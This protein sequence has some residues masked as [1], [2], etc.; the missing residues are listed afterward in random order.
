MSAIKSRFVINAASNFA[1]KAL[2]A[3]ITLLMVPIY[4]KYLGLESYGL[5]GFFATLQAAFGVLD[6]GMTATLNRGLAR[7]S[8]RHE[9]NQE[10][11]D[12][13]KTLRIIYYV[14]SLSIGFLIVVFSPL[15]SKYWIKSTIDTST[16]QHAIMMMGIAISLQWPL[17]FFNSGILGLQHQAKANMIS[18]T[19][20]LVRAMGAFITLS[21]LPNVL[22]F[23][24]WQAFASMLGVYVSSKIL[25][26]L[27]PKGEVGRFNFKLIT[28]IKGYAIGMSLTGIMS[29]GLTQIDKLVVSAVVPLEEFAYYSLAVTFSSIIQYL[30]TPLSIALLPKL[31]Q[32]LEN[33]E[34]SKFLE[35]YH[36]SCQILVLLVIPI[37]CLLAL[38]PSEF[39]YIWTGNKHIAEQGALISGLLILSS[40]LNAIAGQFY[41]LQLAH[42]KSKY[43][44]YINALALPLTFPLMLFFTKNFGL[45]GAASVMVS[46]NLY[47][48]IMNFYIS[49]Q[50]LNQVKL[51]SWIVR[52]FI[53]PTTVS[54]C[55]LALL[56]RAFP[57]LDSRINSLLILGFFWLIA[58]IGSVLVSPIFNEICT[59]LR[60]KRK[61]L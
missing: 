19:L 4:L 24:A 32:H 6:L 22:A 16:I 55:L 11:R 31:T 38:Y 1:G 2:S 23:F 13:T 30:S 58:F 61:L 48:L 20:N 8:A 56:H 9:L 25:W 14:L 12:F 26:D 59:V 49:K 37:C 29:L 57:I 43:G 40:G 44:V 3:L 15:I 10:M 54:L 21:I 27:L 18:V 47:Y 60:Q 42:G 36:K 51:I 50:W 53:F 33:R 45:V 41:I 34:F 7:Y 46:L 35:I 39:L 28:K 5:V 52:V 17:G